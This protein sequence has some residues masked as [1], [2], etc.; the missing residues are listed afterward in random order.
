VMKYIDQSIKVNKRKDKMYNAYNLISLKPDSISVSCLYEMLEGQVAVLSS[1]KLSAGEVAEVLDAMRTSAMYRA[2][3]ESY[4]LYPAKRLPGFLEKNNIPEVEV[5]NSRL[6]SELLRIGDTTVIAKDEKG[7]AHFN[8][9]FRNAENLK[10]AILALKESSGITWSDAEMKNILE[11]FE[12]VFNHKFFTG[13]SGTFYKYEGLGSIYWHMV[14][15]LL[16]AIGENITLA[17]NTGASSE[18]IHALLRHFDEVKKGMGVHKS[19]DRYG[20][21]PFEPYSHTPSM[22]GVQQPGMTGQVK[23]EIISR[24]FELGLLVEQGQITLNPVVLQKSEFI[25]PSKYA[26]FPHLTYTYCHVPFV[27]LLDQ[28]QGIDLEMNDGII[29]FVDGY[30]LSREDTHSI[31]SRNGLIVKVIVHFNADSWNI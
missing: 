29:R 24:F 23:E 9:T 16:V 6:L 31:L 14:A 17:K 2:D 8:G 15:K 1:G 19:P 22:A 3:Q 18:T 25:Y 27:Y 12:K 28:K 26:S 21:C 7:M 4:M 20:A 11:L 10:K 13:R 30:T 5:K